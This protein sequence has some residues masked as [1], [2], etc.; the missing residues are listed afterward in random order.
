MRGATDRSMLDAGLR[1][2]VPKADDRTEVVGGPD[3][4]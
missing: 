2:I 3:D 1:A 4:L